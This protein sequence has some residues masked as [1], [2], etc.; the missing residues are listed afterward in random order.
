MARY[1]LRQ[2][3]HIVFTWMFRI[4]LY[5]TEQVR[6]CANDCSTVGAAG[7]GDSRRELEAV[8][9][10]ILGCSVALHYVL[11]YTAHVSFTA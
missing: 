10:T 9:D 6:E 5:Y 11:H 8:N 4:Q 2:D 1:A 3:M 7:G